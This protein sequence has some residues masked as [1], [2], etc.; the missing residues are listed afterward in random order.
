MD[1]GL[2]QEEVSGP[3]GVLVLLL[4]GILHMTI[5]DLRPPI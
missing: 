3:K 1:L 5:K 4:E 2:I